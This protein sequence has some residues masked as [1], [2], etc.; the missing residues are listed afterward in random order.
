MTKK[1]SLAE[2]AAALIKNAGITA[3]AAA[4]LGINRSSLHRRLLRNKKLAEVVHE[5]T[6]MLKDGAEGLVAKAIMTDKD[7]VTARWFLDRRA[8]ERG[9]GSNSLEVRL[10]DEQLRQVIATFGGDPEKLAK[11]EERLAEEE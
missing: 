4:D 11:L 2:C 6:E 10:P 8:K 3:H 7:V 5:A 9:Y 1:T